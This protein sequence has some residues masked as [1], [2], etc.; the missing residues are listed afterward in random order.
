FAPFIHQ[1]AI[2]FNVQVFLT[3]HSKECID[4]F[5]NNVPEASDFAYHAL[6]NTSEGG[7]KVKEYNGIKYKKLLAAGDVDL[8]KAR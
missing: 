1:L 3:S 6:V 8:R 4:A 5:V 7:I 2:K